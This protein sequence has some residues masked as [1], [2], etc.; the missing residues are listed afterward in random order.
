M[1]NQLLNVLLQMTRSERAY[2][3]GQACA[4]PIVLIAI[5]IIYLVRR[6]RKKRA[7]E[8]KGNILDK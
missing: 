4:L 1:E 7:E 2:Q 5:L 6:K 8:M 3:L